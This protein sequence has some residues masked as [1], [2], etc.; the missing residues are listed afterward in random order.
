[1]EKGEGAGTNQG[2][3]REVEDRFKNVT[4]GIVLSKLRLRAQ[5]E[6]LCL[7]AP[8]ACSGGRRG[9]VYVPDA[10][11]GQ[12]ILKRWS[13]EQRKVYCWAEQGEGVAHAPST[14]NPP[15]GFS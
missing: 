8:S 3:K 15:E 11:Q 14:H 5:G 2:W 12:K 10:Q 9:L 7:W 1:M 6:T 4:V 13:L